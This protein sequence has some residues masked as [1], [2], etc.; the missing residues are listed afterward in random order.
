M[1]NTCF[2]VMVENCESK[3]PVEWDHGEDLITRL[4]PIA[5]IPQLVSSGQIRHSLVV[6]A[7]YYFH[8]W[9]GRTGKS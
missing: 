1:A 4:V 7:L 6:V 5:D 9:Q 8:L 2:T 3:H